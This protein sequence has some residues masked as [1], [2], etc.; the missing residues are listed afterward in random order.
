M[1]LFY[2]NYNP[3]E[4]VYIWPHLGNIRDSA[5]NVSKSILYQ[6]CKLVGQINDLLC[7]VCNMNSCVKT[8]IYIYIHIYICMYIYVCMCVCILETCLKNTPATI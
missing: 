2:I 3:I 6:R 1:P 8:E 5:Q 4:R 7:F